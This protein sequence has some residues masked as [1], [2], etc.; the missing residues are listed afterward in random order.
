LKPVALQAAA[1]NGVAKTASAG[2]ATPLGRGLL[3]AGFLAYA[4]A[5]GG[6]W[7]LALKLIPG[8]LTLTLLGKT[9]HTASVHD[10]LNNVFL[11]FLLLPSALW[12][13]CAVV[14][15]KESSI[16]QLLL[17][18]TPSLNTDLA[19][20]V[21]GQGHVLD[22]VGRVLMLGAS[23]VSGGWLHEAIKAATGVNLGP[24]PIPFALQ[25]P[26]YFAIYTFFDYWTHRTD[27][28][29]FFWP[30]HRYH[31]S[32]EDFGVVTS[33]RQHPV[34][35]TAIFIVNFP[36]AALGA[37]AEVMIYVNVLVIGIGFLI[38]SKIDADWGFVGRWLIQ[39]PNHHRAHHKL[40]M[41]RPTGHFAIAPIWDRLFGTW[42]EDKPDPK[43]VIGVD[44]PYQHGLFVPRDMLRDYAHFWMGWFGG[45][46]DGPQSDLKLFKSKA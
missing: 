38:H 42:Y 36:L 7:W 31:H 18:R 41:S 28:T 6:A 15:W 14:G 22:L 13:E 17:A 29:K 33:V 5:A 44:T 25:L 3:I 26:L 8:E 19:V 32:A 21:L 4:A 16:R 35:F 34:T 27:H 12:I 30:L 10:H 46:S 23:M 2:G 40:D 1:E 39:S 37:P 20:F 24:P 45:R 9:L 43:L 11:V